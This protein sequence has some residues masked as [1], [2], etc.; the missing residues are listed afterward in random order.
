MA[1]A[2]IADGRWLLVADWRFR[3]A[4]E[5]STG[6]EATLDEVAP[7]HGLDRL[8]GVADAGGARTAL[9]GIRGRES[10]WFVQGPDGPTYT[11]LSPAASAAWSADGR[12]LAY[13]VGGSDTLF[14]QG[15]HGELRVGIGRPAGPPVWARDGRS[16]YV[17]VRADDGAGTLLR[18][19]AVDGAIEVLRDRLYISIV[20]TRLAVHEDGRRLFLSLASPVAP[21]AE[22][23]HSPTPR[24]PLHIYGLDL[25]SSSLEA[26][27]HTPH[28]DFAPTTAGVWLYWTRNA[29]ADA[30]V[31]LP[32]NGGEA[33]T[34]VEDAIL[35][36]WS[37]DGRRIAFTYGLGGVDG[38][39]SSDAAV[40][41]LAQDG[42]PFGPPAPI[43]TG[44]HEDFTPRWSPDSSWIAYHSHRS[45]RPVAYY[46]GQGT[47]DDVYLRRPAAPMSE[48]IRLTD[49][50]WEVGPADWSPDGRRLV[51]ASWERGGQ[52]GVAKPWI[53]TIDPADGRLVSVERLRLPVGVDNLTMPVWS[54]DGRE[55]AADVRRGERRHEMWILSADGSGGERLVEFE[56]GTY[57]G[58]HWTPDGRFLVY[59]AL[60]D[61]RMQLFRIRRSGGD[62]EQLTHDGANLLHPRV[63]PD[64]RWIA[65]TRIVRVKEVWRK[66]FR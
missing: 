9:Y 12:G 10:G 42:D 37:P 26:I 61:G 55:I 27:V 29:Y 11:G 66:E 5:L 51:F 62:P 18:V 53:A 44:F 47:T 52:P 7:G 4:I 19:G 22:A 15:D 36:S 43:V 34:I 64:G 45:A 58:V 48:E 2:P 24:R 60:V 35:P 16:I 6:R 13:V 17:I 8:V 38:A 56:S 54:P 59:A 65:A 31:V 25:T 41:D 23:R 40:I 50:G 39:L 20:T 33:R 46:A 14:I 57:G 1:A 30:V 49:F 63:S 28:D 32:A 21:A 3:K